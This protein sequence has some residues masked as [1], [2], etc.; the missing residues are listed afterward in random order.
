M[1]CACDHH[2]LWHTALP[3]IRA[4][5]LTCACARHRSYNTDPSGTYTK[6][7]ARAIGSGSEGAQSALQEHYRKD[8]TLKEAETLAL[9]TLKQVMEEKVS[10]EQK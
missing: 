6:Y 2:H 4:H 7:Q 9:N 5:S 10:A 8:M 3:A 1:R